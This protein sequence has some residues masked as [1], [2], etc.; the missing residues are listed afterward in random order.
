[1]LTAADILLFSQSRVFELGGMIDFSD[2]SVDDV[3]AAR[4]LSTAW[5]SI[6]SAEPL[7]GAIEMLRGSSVRAVVA[8]QQTVSGI[9]P[10]GVILKAHR[11]Y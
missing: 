2:H 10:K 6:G 11:R 8:T 9:L 1:V 4:A 3:I 5:M 7:A